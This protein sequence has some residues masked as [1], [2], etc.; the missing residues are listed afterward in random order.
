M[1][2]NRDRTAKNAPARG[3]HLKLPRSKLPAEQGG[4]RQEGE[5]IV[6]GLKGQ[7]DL[8]FEGSGDVAVFTS[9]WRCCTAS[10]PGA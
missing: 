4:L 2:Q 1:S 7:C 5:A 3:F 10:I 9:I 6:R 8:P